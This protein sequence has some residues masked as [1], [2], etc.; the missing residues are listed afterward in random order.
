MNL[1]RTQYSIGLAVIAVVLPDLLGRRPLLLG[2]TVLMFGSMITVGAIGATHPQPT[3]AIANL[4]IVSRSHHHTQVASHS[5]GTFDLHHLLFRRPYSSLPWYVWT[6]TAFISGKQA[7]NVLANRASPVA[8]DRSS[9]LST[10]NFLQGAHHHSSTPPVEA[11]PRDA[12]FLL[13]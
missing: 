6:S 5:Q 8:G 12:L 3:G 7:D 4:V 10:P 2:G 11:V 9:G 13:S 1:R